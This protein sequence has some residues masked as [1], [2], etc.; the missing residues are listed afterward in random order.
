MDV[1]LRRFLLKRW[2]LAIGNSTPRVMRPFDSIA[3][4]LKFGLFL[5]VSLDHGLIVEICSCSKMLL[6]GPRKIVC[7][8]GLLVQ[9]P[10]YTGTSLY[11]V[12]AFS[13]G[14]AHSLTLLNCS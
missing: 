11:S 9:F 1:E 12:K 5:T 10:F 6:P 8:L 3:E 7:V 2:I 14:S 13:H 4:V